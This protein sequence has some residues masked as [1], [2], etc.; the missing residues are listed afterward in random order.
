ML[1][2]SRQR[3]MRS[4]MEE[5]G[6]MWSMI[7]A[8]ARIRISSSSLLHDDFSRVE[9]IQKQADMSTF[10]VVIRGASTRS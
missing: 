10:V 6:E 8:V 1:E 4:M 5:L 9:V 2:L 3:V 7:V